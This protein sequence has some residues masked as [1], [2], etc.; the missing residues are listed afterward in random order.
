MLHLTIIA[1]GKLKESYWRTA[2]AE[3]IKRLTPFARVEIVELREEAFD[4]KS[5]AEIIKQKEAEKIRKE[6]NQRPSAYVI[7]LDEHGRQFSSPAFAEQLSNITMKQSSDIIFVI[8][9]PLGLDPV[10]TKSAH[11]ALSL[12]AHTITH[13]MVRVILLETLYRAMMIQ[14]N[15]TYHY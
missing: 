13:Q 2:A 10:I 11:L 7:A 15:R 1:L 9:G 14:N 4:A 8:G 12:G 5:R 6:I 3:Y